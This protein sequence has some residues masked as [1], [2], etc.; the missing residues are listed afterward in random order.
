MVLTVEV[1]VVIVGVVFIP[2]VWPVELL[3]VMRVVVALVFDSCFL[4]LAFVA[5]GPVCLGFL[6]LHTEFTFWFGCTARLAK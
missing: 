5:L 6:V 3:F 4:L 1:V 2:I